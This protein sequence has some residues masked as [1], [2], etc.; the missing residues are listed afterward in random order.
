MPMTQG[1]QGLRELQELQELQELNALRYAEGIDAMLQI[2]RGRTTAV[3][4]S[5]NVGMFRRRALRKGYPNRPASWSEEMPP[6]ATAGFD[7]S[8]QFGALQ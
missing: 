5:R 3:F 7:T 2:A 8:R 4:A 1:L 6:S